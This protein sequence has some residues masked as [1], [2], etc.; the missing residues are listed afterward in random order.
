M[1]A[2]ELF[3]LNFGTVKQICQDYKIQPQ[4]VLE[5]VNHQKEQLREAQIK[6]KKLKNE[7]WQTKIPQ[8]VE[9]TKE[10]CKIPFLFFETKSMGND[11]LRE[12]ASNL[13][14][15]KPGFYFLISKNDSKISFLATVDKALKEKINLRKLSLWLKEKYALK[16]GGPDTLIQ[17]GGEKLP[18]NL[19][20]ELIK[21]IEEN[22]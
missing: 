17:G 21:W 7:L 2:I 5:T 13:E 8:L 11:E 1:K 4:Q 18:S 16:G 22:A 19:E 14:K 10:V 3:Q 6:I 15:Q 12:L 9:S 20:N